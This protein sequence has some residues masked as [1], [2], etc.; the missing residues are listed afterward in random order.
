MLLTDI[1]RDEWGFDGFVTSDWVWGTHDAVTSLEAGLDVEM[2]LRLHR[3]RDLPG[4]ARRPGVPGDRAALGPPHPGDM[5]C[6]LRQPRRRR[7]RA[8]LVAGPDHRALARD[9]A[10]AGS[11]LLKNEPVDDVPVLPLPPSIRRLAVIGRLA[12]R[13]NTGDRGSSLVPSAIDGVRPAGLRDALPCRG[14]SSGHR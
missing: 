1:L 10:V 14:R 3:A 13:S 5:P 7:S 4:A 11:V 2:P 6:A 8:A 9:V 12:D